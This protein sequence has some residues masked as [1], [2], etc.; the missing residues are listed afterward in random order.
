MALDPT[1]KILQE[2]E[3]KLD[4]LKA[5]DLYIAFRPPPPLGQILPF[6]HYNYDNYPQPFVAGGLVTANIDAIFNITSMWNYSQLRSSE[7]EEALTIL[8]LT[9]G[10]KG[11]TEYFLWR[12]AGDYVVTDK[13]I[14]TNTFR[15]DI[16]Y[17]NRIERVDLHDDIFAESDFDLVA[18]VRKLNTKFQV[19]GSTDPP[20]T[21]KDFVIKL[22][23]ALENSDESTWIIF[24]VPNDMRIEFLEGNDYNQLFGFKTILRLSSS[25]YPWFVAQV[26]K[27][28]RLDAKKLYES[29]AEF[30]EMRN[31]DEVAGLPLPKDFFD[32]KLISIYWKI[33][34]N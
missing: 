26:A 19:I 21:L 25:I 11:M 15:K 31:D 27:P 23:I 34:Y 17:D 14:I 32:L 8:D 16:N 5:I 12:T 3:A 29:L 6:E 10:Q 18:K 7:T 1:F 2:K 22:S 20:T 13:G 28:I 24:T 4:P 9:K 30:P 33:P